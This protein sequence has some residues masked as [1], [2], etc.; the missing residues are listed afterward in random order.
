MFGTRLKIAL[1]FG[2]LFALQVATAQESGFYRQ[3]WAEPEDQ[4][5]NHK[6]FRV[7]DRDLSLHEN[8]GHRREA[9]ANGLALVR[10]PDDLFTVSRAELYMEL[11]GGHPGTHNKRVSPNGKA[12]YEI[13]E[14][15]TAAGNCTFHYP[16]MPL[17]IFHLVTGMNALQYSCE[18]PGPA[19]G[20]YFPHEIALRIWMKPE[21]TALNE[22]GL[23]DLTAQATVASRTLADETTLT[24]QISES[25]AGDIAAVHWYGRYLDFDDNGEGLENDWHGFTYARQ[26]VNHIGTA[27]E[28]PYDI[29][30]N[31]RMIPTQGRPMAVRAEIEF[32]NGIIYRTP[33]QD[34]LEFP[35]DRPAVRLYSCTDLPVKFWS[36]ANR[37]VTAELLLP[38]DLSGVV[39]AELRTKIWD[40]GAGTVEHP[41][42]M[43][44]KPYKIATETAPH[45]P[46]YRNLPVD[47]SHLKPG[48]NTFTLLSETKHHG[49]EMA[50]P[51][52]CLVLRWK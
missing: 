45:K 36:R 32:T 43:N 51:G 23:R 14:V 12:I 20:H 24:L 28:A 44:E 47:L 19:W 33:V 52:P 11:W 39:Q 21:H 25:K 10:V 4:V 37:K 3:Y 27:T 29:A 7:N 30:W 35:K 6:Q 48:R 22:A 41:F 49:I 16:V 46:I 40:G 8:Y 15:G 38:E 18:K 31:T 50:L 26:P 5:N 17:E 13:P 1:V 34:G 42:H 2:V 9:K